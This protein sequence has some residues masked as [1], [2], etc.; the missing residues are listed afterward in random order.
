MTTTSEMTGVFLND[1]SCKNEF[2]QLIRWLSDQL[3]PET[4]FELIAEASDN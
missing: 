2:L 4:H 3:H 1:Q